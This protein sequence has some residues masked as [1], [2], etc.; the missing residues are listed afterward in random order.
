MWVYFLKLNFNFL[1]LVRNK[2]LLKKTK[3]GG[4]N[5]YSKEYKS[6]LRYLT[7]KILSYQVWTKFKL[8]QNCWFV[9]VFKFIKV[10]FFA[11]KLS[12]RSLSKEINV[13]IYKE[14]NH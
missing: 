5:L 2:S 8:A 7:F 9:N 13:N 10:N 12:Y 3:D 1:N 11:Q 4:F 6:Y 14:Q